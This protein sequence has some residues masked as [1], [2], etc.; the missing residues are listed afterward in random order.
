MNKNAATAAAIAAA[1]VVTVTPL[2]DASGVK[3]ALAAP[4]LVSAA[5]AAYHAAKQFIEPKDGDK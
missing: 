5:A 4:T 1:T 2:P 3:I